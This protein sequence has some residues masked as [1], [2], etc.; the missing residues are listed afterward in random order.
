LKLKFYN[1]IEESTTYRKRLK[2]L[3]EPGVY[4]LRLCDNKRQR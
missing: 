4:R 3:V 1:A 2:A